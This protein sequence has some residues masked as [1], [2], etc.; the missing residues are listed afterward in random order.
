MKKTTI[1]QCLTRMLVDHSISITEKNL[2][3]KINILF[4]DC[5][6]MSDA[7]FVEVSERLRKGEL[8]GKLPASKDFLE[9]RFSQKF[10]QFKHL[11]NDK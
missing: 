7:E 1:I 11:L 8:Y 6:D 3:Q 2:E 9:A 10:S 4:E 5:K